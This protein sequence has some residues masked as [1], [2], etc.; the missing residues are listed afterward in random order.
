MAVKDL[1]RQ[2]DER[3]TADGGGRLELERAHV[4]PWWHVGVGCGLAVLTYA[5]MLGDGHTIF[6][7]A[8]KEQLFEHMS[9]WLFLLSSLLAWACW[10]RSRRQAATV[11]PLRRLSYVLLALLFFVAFGEE[12]SWGQHYFG[13]DTPEAIGKINQQEELNLHNL[14]FI[15]SNDDEGKKRG[16]AG[17]LLNSNRLFDY[18]MLGL[19]VVAPWGSLLWPAFGRLYQSLGGPKM[20]PALALPMG[21]NIALSVVS[22]VY[23]VDNGFR[24][25][26][27]SEIRELNYALLCFLGMLWLWA[28]ERQR[29]ERE[30][31]PST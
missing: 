23:L 8:G 10:V 20:S 25:M 15:D 21:F 19:F 11:P 31:A 27:T 2:V 9:A 29:Q 12:L 14:T 28:V 5:V 17:K 18:F 22:L 3:S 30:K 16:W 4:S 26:A 6:V 24:H 13:F 1:A 7:F